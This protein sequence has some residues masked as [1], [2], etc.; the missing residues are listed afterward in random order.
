MVLN[1]LADCPDPMFNDFTLID[2]S[3]DTDY[4]MKYGDSFD[5][6]CDSGYYIPYEEYG[7]CWDLTVDATRTITCLFGGVWDMEL[8]DCE[9]EH[10]QQSRVHKSELSRL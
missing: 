10:L 3:R 9:R 6:S 2:G 1:M 4:E 8:P 7:Q 5:V